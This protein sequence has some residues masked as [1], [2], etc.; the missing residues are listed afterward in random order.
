[1][2]AN[3]PYLAIPNLVIAG[4]CLWAATAQNASSLCR[5]RERSAE[6]SFCTHK[7]PLQ[8]DDASSIQSRSAPRCALC[9]LGRGTF[10]QLFHLPYVT[11]GEQF[12]DTILLWED[13]QERTILEIQRVLALYAIAVCFLRL[14]GCLRNN[15]QCL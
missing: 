11:D 14:R 15:S 9:W 7:I 6:I 2:S 5:V 12:I 4:N 10:S 13:F 1:M 8:R 3:I